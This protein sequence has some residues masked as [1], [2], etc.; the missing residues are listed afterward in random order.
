MLARQLWL[1]KAEVLKFK[2]AHNLAEAALLGYYGLKE[3]L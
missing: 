2:K 1:D 3:T